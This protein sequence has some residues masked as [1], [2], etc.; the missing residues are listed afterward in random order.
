[1]KNCKWPWR[2]R[3]ISLKGLYLSNDWLCIWES[4]LSC[5]FQPCLFV[6]GSIWQR[7]IESPL[8]VQLLCTRFRQCCR[9]FSMIALPLHTDTVYSS[10]FISFKLQLLCLRS[11]T[12]ELLSPKQQFMVSFILFHW[13]HDSQIIDC[14]HLYCCP[15]AWFKVCTFS[16]E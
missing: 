2:R 1:M 6:L 14:Y 9:F 5:A 8:S 10:N 11:E 13:L 3:L 7:A 12:D 16:C 15:S 4:S